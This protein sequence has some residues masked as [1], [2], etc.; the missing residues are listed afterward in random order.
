[1]SCTLHE[2]IEYARE[3]NMQGCIERYKENNQLA[4]WLEELEKLREVLGEDYNLD[5]LKEL[6]EADRAGQCVIHY[7]PNC[8]KC[9]YRHKD[10]GNC[11]IVGGFC[12]AVPAAHCPLIPELFARIEEEKAKAK[13]AETKA[14]S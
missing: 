9:H 12:T 4:D 8:L 3:G 6:V 2:A 7:E 13:V 5:R 14:E 1:M 11:T 10:N